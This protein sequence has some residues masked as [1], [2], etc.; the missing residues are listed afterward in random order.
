MT[1]RL[2]PP[3]RPATS[4][5]YVGADVRSPG[6]RTY[7]RLWV[8]LVA[9]FAADQLSKYWVVRHIDA[10]T[11]SNPAPLPVIDGFFYFVNISNAGA[12]WGIFA[13]YSTWLGW[14]GA[15]ALVAIF[16]FRR[17]LELHRPLLQYA[18]GLL[19]GGI[20][21][22]LCDRAFYGHVVDFLDFHL[23]WGY[24]Y[25]AFNLADSGITIGVAIYFIYSFRDLWP[26]NKSTPLR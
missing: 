13:G 25:P 18:F 23:P 20:L 19:C 14:L 26:A 16:L 1:P 8:T 6:A 4:G 11:Y 12:A 21:G 15:V 5:P 7:A 17:Q 3:L 24:R 9:L 22:N 10:D 2:D